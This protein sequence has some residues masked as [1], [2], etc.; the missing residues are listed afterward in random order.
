MTASLL[1]PLLVFSGGDAVTRTRLPVETSGAPVLECSACRGEYE[2]LSAIVYAPA[3]VE[4]LTVSASP[5]VAP[6]GQ[7]GAFSVDLRIVK[8]WYQGGI[9]DLERNHP[10]EYNPRRVLTAEL[11]LKDDALV[12]AQG[13]R[14]F[15]RSTAEDGTQ[16]YLPCSGAT[17]IRLEGARP[18][19]A[20]TLQPVGIPAGMS[21]EFVVTVHV[22][23]SAAPGVYSG[24]V[25]FTSDA[26]AASLPLRVTVRPFELEP[27]RL[28]YSLYYRGRLSEDGE[29][30]IGSDEKSAQQYRAEIADMREH[31]V[32]YPTNYQGWGPGLRK[33]LD[34]RREEGLPTEAFYT[35]AAGHSP[36]EVR[37]WLSLCRGYG[38]KDVYFYGADEAEGD[39]LIAQRADWKGV[40]DAGGKTFVATYH[41]SK[42]Y[43]VM[44]SLLN[45]A[46]VSGLP[47]AETAAAWHQIG[48]ECFA[49]LC[50]QVGVERPEVYRRNF[51]LVLAKSGYDGAM[52]YAYQHAFHSIWNDFDDRD[53]RDHVFA[54]PTVNGVVPT[55][56]WEG[57]REAVDDARY[58]ATLEKAIV[59]ADDAEVAREALE[60][61]KGLD[62]QTVNL[63][64]TREHMAAW[65][66]RL[67]EA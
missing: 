52:D 23:F 50:P 61:L 9:R 66:E 53:Y 35:L 54:Y 64:G 26:G 60:W 24:Q 56:E 37:K 40:Q 10:V 18:I 22:P 29:P 58:V 4:G 15:L 12:R 46:V 67:K 65:I 25:S 43:E 33:V 3:G 44:G 1:V 59:E 13:G 28:T 39:A 8:W 11:L 19:D 55:L 14:N 17:S 36:A 47:K 21:R 49:Y 31:G 5:L 62:P 63:T 30:R 51:G 48:G 2:S 27:S 57:F 7:G 16:T 41:R 20:A 42:A 45:L 6:T 32:L 38:Y 34:I